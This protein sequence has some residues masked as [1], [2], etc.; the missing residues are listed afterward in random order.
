MNV[1]GSDVRLRYTGIVLVL[2]RLFSILTGAIFV[3]IITRKLTIEHYG[4]WRMIASYLA[5]ALVLTNVYNYWLPR[6]IAR[7]VNTSKTGLVLSLTL[8]SAA[9]LFYVATAFWFSISFNQ[10]LSILLIAAP[11]VILYYAQYAIES[12]ASGYAPQLNGYALIV[13]ELVKIG[14]GFC[15]VFLFRIE[16]SGAIL[17]VVGAQIASV[18]FSTAVNFKVVA[19]SKLDLDIAGSWLRHS[20]L[21]IF[22]TSV[23]IVTGLDVILVRLASGSEEPIAYYGVA[24]TAAGVVANA[25]AAASGLYPRLLARARI[26]EAEVT[27]KLMYMFAIPISVFIF[28]YA[29]PISAVFG[30]KYLAAVNTIRAATM[31][32]LLYIFS[33]LL[34]TIILGVEKRD[35]ERLTFK[36]IVN[37]MLFKLPFLNYI[38]SFVY[39]IILYVLLSTAQGYAEV[40]FRWIISGVASNSLAIVVKLA[41]LRRDF[42]LNISTSTVISMLRYIAASLFANIFSFNIWRVLPVERIVDLLLSLMPPAVFTAMVYSALLAVVDRDFKQLL[43]AAIREMMSNLKSA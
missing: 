22:S 24:L 11:Q 9:T 4:L 1:S 30:L 2:S 26:S 25:I 17:A 39:L 41:A 16:L 27:M 38:I 6:T 3:L 33:S 34:D 14:L 32:S 19:V 13:F 8:G 10:P 43:K 23:G 18:L 12:V 42:R 31:A 5:Y 35:A 40:S 29:E 37:S 15:L 21:P 7:G 36:G 28:F 20:W